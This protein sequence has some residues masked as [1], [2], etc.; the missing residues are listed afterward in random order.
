MPVPP[1]FREKGDEFVA[2]VD[3]RRDEF[4]ASRKRIGITRERGWLQQT[5]QGD[6]FVLVLEGDDP[7]KAN[8]LFAASKEPFDVWFKERVGPLAGA[9]FGQP[10]P[11]RPDPIY[12]SAPEGSDAKEAVAV[13]IPLLPGKT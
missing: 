10:I 13:A 3:S 7:V 11:V 8:E 2:E 5:P 9:D 4:I 12:H 6:V 1:Q